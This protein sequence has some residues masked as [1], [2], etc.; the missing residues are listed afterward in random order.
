MAK[1]AHYTINNVWTWNHSSINPTEDCIYEIFARRIMK[2]PWREAMHDWDSLMAYRELN[3][4]TRSLA[5]SLYGLG[6]G[7][8]RVV[9]VYIGRFYDKMVIFFPCII[10]SPKHEFRNI[11]Q[12][13]GASILL[14]SLI[15]SRSRCPG[16]PTAAAAQIKFSLLRSLESH[17]D[18]KIRID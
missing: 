17:S 11:T 9:A 14:W 5:R 7:P 1:S 13:V 18:Q 12:K 6:V 2:P 3:D 4:L 16:K 15:I 8:E 10:H